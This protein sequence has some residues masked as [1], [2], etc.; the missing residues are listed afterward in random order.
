MNLNNL[1]NMSVYTYIGIFSIILATVIA[2]RIKETIGNVLNN[3]LYILIIFLIIANIG[4]RDLMA[5]IVCTLSFF[6]IYQ[7]V[8]EKKIL[9]IIVEKT[10]KI[11][12]SQPVII[13]EVPVNEQEHVQ[14]PVQ[15]PEPISNPIISS[16]SNEAPTVASNVAPTVAPK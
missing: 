5:G 1:T 3:N 6:M 2:P 7:N 9:D 4:K 13:N 11:L 8:T 14:E 10:Q 16:S 15:V 12:E